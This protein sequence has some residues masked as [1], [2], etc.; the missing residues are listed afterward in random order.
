MINRINKTEDIRKR[1]R[2]E[3]KVEYLDKPEHVDAMIRMNEQ[4]EKDHQD[5]LWKSARSS[6]ESKDC[7]VN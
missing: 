4:L 2:E 6:I 7:W 3:G 5:F 1:L